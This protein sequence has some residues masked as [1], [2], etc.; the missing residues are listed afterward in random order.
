MMTRTDRRRFPVLLATIA[1]L[2]VFIAVDAASGPVQAQT[3]AA[4]LAGLSLSSSTL[5]PA[6]DPAVTEYRA[7]VKHNVGQITVSGTPATGVTVTYN[8]A[9]GAALADANDSTAGHQ[10][11]LGVGETVF[12]VAAASGSDTETYTVTMERDASAFLGWTPSRDIDLDAQNTDAVG[13]WSDSTTLWVADSADAKLYAYTLATRARDSSEDI[14]LHADNA[15]PTGIWSDGTTLWVAD[16]ADGKLYAYT[17][18]TKERDD[19]RDITLD[20]ANDNPSALWG[21]TTHIYVAEDEINDKRVYAYTIDTGAA[22]GDRASEKDVNSSKWNGYT[23]AIWSDG[24]TLWAAEGDFSFVVAYSLET[25]MY[26]GR[27]FALRSIRSGTEGSSAM[28]SDGTTAWFK[29]NVADGKLYSYNLPSVAGDTTL[30]AL[31]ITYGSAK[32]AA[33]RPDFAVNKASY[34]AT[35]PSSAGRVTIAATKNNSSS[36]L[37]F[38]GSDGRTLADADTAAGHQVDIGVGYT[39]IFLKITSSSGDA[40][41]YVVGIERDSSLIHGWTP[42]KDINGLLADDVVSPTGIWSNGTTIWVGSNYRKNLYAYTL[43]TGAR[44]SGKDI[45]LDEL[46][47]I[48]GVNSLWGNTTT[49][50]VAGIG[51]SQLRA[52]TLATRVR[53]PDKDISFDAENSSRPGLWS[54]GTTIWVVDRH[55]NK[56]YAYALSDGARQANKDFDLDLLPANIGDIWSDGETMWAVDRRRGSPLTAYK[57][58]LNTNGTTGDDFGKRDPGKDIPMGLI[59]PMGLWS[60][61]R[62]IWVANRNPNKVYSFNMAPK[63]EGAATLTGLAVTYDGGTEAA[64][65]PAFAFDRGAYRAAVPNSAGQVTV[66]PTKHTAASAVSYLDVNGTDIPDAAGPAAGQQ[67]SA[68]VGQTP[69]LVQVTSGTD[70]LTYALTVERDSAEDFRLDAHPGLQLFDCGQQQN[71]GHVEQRGHPLRVPSS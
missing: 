48:R 46:W 45:S 13:M 65:R 54:D 43:A 38:L 57:L 24:T 19:T 4:E 28:W 26:V 18:S 8:D 15:N 30:S 39:R 47:G 66:T 68:H 69:V 50:W 34:E 36:A 58:D 33:L 35:V 49:I 6:F 27:E 7:A 42:T 32:D 56:V 25:G 20:A 5:R 64:L 29:E 60:D 71:P 17:L 62:T 70:S 23:T 10:V 16:D 44:D 59:S 41:T 37:E 40:L 67:V 9:T 53:D 1:A 11:N 14:A 22:G 2:L 31:S 21:N 63:V 52:Y 55:D 3:P 51:D 12:Q 61:G